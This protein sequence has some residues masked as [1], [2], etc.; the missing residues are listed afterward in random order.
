VP[1]ETDPEKINDADRQVEASLLKAGEAYAASHKRSRAENKERAANRAKIKELGLRT[2]AY[3][4]GVRIVKDLTETERSD[5]L[6]DLTLVV[7]ALGH[8]QQE[9]FPEE[10]L[11]AQQ[12]IERAKEKAAKE[13][14]KLQGNEGAPDSDTNPRSNPNAGGAKPMTPEEEAAEQAEGEKVLSGVTSTEVKTAEPRKRRSQS[15]IAE[16]KRKSAG[17][18]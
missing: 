15:E 13:A 6:R 12:R 18:H 8:R 3:Q 16:E 14:A 7:T 4:V 2:D 9:L 17:L 5:F 10:A 11:K 1:M